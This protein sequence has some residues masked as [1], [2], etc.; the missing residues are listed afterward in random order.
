MVITPHP[1]HPPSSQGTGGKAGTVMDGQPWMTRVPSAVDRSTG[2]EEKAWELP[3][4]VLT[5]SPDHPAQLS[6]WAPGQ[7]PP[8]PDPALRS[9]SSMELPAVFSVFTLT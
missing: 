7:H 5:C 1:H 4:S 8:G 2:R 9:E 6:T 3:L